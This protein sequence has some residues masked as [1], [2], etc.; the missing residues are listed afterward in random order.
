MMERTPKLEQF[1][2][3][4]KDMLSKWIDLCGL[5]EN[6]PSKTNYTSFE[7]LLENLDKKSQQL[8]LH[9]F[10]EL[11]RVVQILISDLND[12]NTKTSYT[13]MQHVVETGDFLQQWV[14]DL[15]SNPDY[16]PDTS[17]RKQTLCNLMFEENEEKASTD[18]NKKLSRKK[19]LIIDD[20]S[21]IALYL[22]DMLSDE[23]DCTLAVTFPDAIQYLET[24]KF[25]IVLSDLNLHAGGKT[26]LDI[27]K[28]IKKNDL[29]IPFIMITGAQTSQVQESLARKEGCLLFISKPFEEFEVKFVLKQLRWKEDKKSAK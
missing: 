8:H 10:S 12:E 29:N 6:D 7:K 18:S 27:I 11:V 5:I 28:H 17:M 20:D 26:G 19:V 22:C 15:N 3:Q 16:M 14:K 13:V 1:I 25:D 24:D 9:R 4:A 2:E 23:Y 21:E